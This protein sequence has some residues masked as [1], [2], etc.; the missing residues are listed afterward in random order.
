MPD[1]RASLAQQVDQA[2]S[3]IPWFFPLASPVSLET[4][5]LSKS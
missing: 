5:A 3:S 2:E 4:L 1:S